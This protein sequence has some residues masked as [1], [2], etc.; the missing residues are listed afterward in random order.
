VFQGR[1]AIVKPALGQI[2]RAGAIAAV[3]G[4]VIIATIWFVASILGAVTIPL[5]PVI[6]VSIC[7]TCR[8]SRP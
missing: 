7:R 2:V 6:F 3:A 8:R 1:R 5:L 4:A